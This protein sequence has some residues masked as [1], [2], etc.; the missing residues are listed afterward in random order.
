MDLYA[1][2]LRAPVNRLAAAVTSQR[3]VSREETPLS[4]DELRYLLERCG[5]KQ[6]LLKFVLRIENRAQHKNLCWKHNKGL[7]QY[8]ADQ[9]PRAFVEYRILGKQMA[10]LNVALSEAKKDR[11]A[12]HEAAWIKAGMPRVKGWQPNAN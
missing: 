6:R 5:R 2:L 7:R 10:Q 9:E 11:Q 4:I 8:R 1:I 3:R 12:A